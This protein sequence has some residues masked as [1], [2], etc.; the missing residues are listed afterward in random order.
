MP[1]RLAA[2]NGR[3][4]VKGMPPESTHCNN[5]GAEHRK[6]IHPPFKA[7]LDIPTPDPEFRG[8]RTADELMCLTPELA[9][10]MTPVH[11]LAWRRGQE[12]IDAAAKR[13]ATLDPA[14]RRK[15]LREDWTRLL[16]EVAPTE[17][18]TL[19][20]EKKT[21]DGVVVERLLL[22]VEPG[23]TVP[24][25]ILSKEKGEGKRPVVLCFAQEGKQEFLK[26][27][28]QEIAALL[29]GGV[30]VCLVDLRGCGETRPGSDRSRSSSA[31][32]IAAS[33]WMLGRSL[34]GGRL[35]DLRT[36]L[37][38]LRGRPDVDAQR[39]C[40][41]GDSFAAVN[42]PNAEFAV[43]HDAEK[44]PA[45]GEPLGS[46]L[47]LLGL[48]FEEDV[49]GGLGHGGLVDY[50]SVLDNPFLYVPADVMVPEV[51]KVG[52]LGSLT[53]ALAPRPLLL[54]ELIDGRNRRAEADRV[55]RTYAAAQTAYRD[56]R[57]ADAFRATSDPV[58]SGQA[59]WLLGVIRR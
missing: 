56:A 25:V 7:W 50:H 40:L 46:L 18:K 11:L 38:F 57:S 31:T 16:G 52:D 5:I 3:G 14:A 12:Q 45:I 2:V 37:R 32:A 44:Q 9:G 15:Q 13:L 51:L 42:G 58:P 47:V 29:E 24:A 41:W 20:A 43:P 6:G 26:R 19:R 27:R 28:A 55:Q 21:A 17:P 33:E 23:V 30:V 10:K 22:E 8:R 36:V 1:E 53:A 35:R 49:R 39:I 4:S 59:R 34:V 54:E 48:L